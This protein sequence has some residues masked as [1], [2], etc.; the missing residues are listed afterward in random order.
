MKALQH[1]L[2]CETLKGSPD[3]KGLYKL[4]VYSQRPWGPWGRHLRGFMRCLGNGSCPQEMTNYPHARNGA[5]HC[6]FTYSC[7]LSGFLSSRSD[8]G[9]NSLVPNQYGRAPKGISLDLSLWRGCFHRTHKNFLCSSAP[10]EF[11]WLEVTG[12]LSDTMITLGSFSE[13]E[14]PTNKNPQSHAKYRTVSFSSYGFSTKKS[15]LDNLAARDQEQIQS[16]Y[17]FPKNEKRRRILDVLAAERAV[18]RWLVDEGVVPLRGKNFPLLLVVADIGV[19]PESQQGDYDIQIIIWAGVVKRLSHQTFCWQ[20][21]EDWLESTG[22]AGQHSS[23][24]G[25]WINVF[26]DSING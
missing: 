26:S 7:F 14:N 8:K 18:D 24:L 15:L 3:S 13:K 22:H 4:D 12:R 10:I 25:P 16:L 21:R 19:D 5:H 17:L 6:R 9:K 11:G 23:C 2:C 20:R 1:R